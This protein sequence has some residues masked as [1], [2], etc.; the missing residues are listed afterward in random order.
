M[1]LNFE[2]ERDMR[3]LEGRFARESLGE[4]AYWSEMLGFGNTKL[5]EYWFDFL[6]KKITAEKF[7]RHI[8]WN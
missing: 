4:S 6:L 7:I 8:R 2:V 3:E 1:N 5:E